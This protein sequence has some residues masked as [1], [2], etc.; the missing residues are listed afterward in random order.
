MAIIDFK[1]IP[2]ANS[3]GG[4]Q[5]TFELFARDFANEILGLKIISQPN[6]GADG[7]KDFLAEEIRNGT[8]SKSSIRWLVSCKHFAHSGKSVS[9]ND[10]LNISDRMH[11]HNADGFIGFY[12]TIA[13]SGLGSRL[14]ALKKD[15]S[16]EIFD[17]KKIE[18]WLLKFKDTTLFKRYFPKSFEKWGGKKY[19]PTI[20][21]GEYQPLHC[22]VCGKDLL[23]NKTYDLTVE[24]GGLIVFVEKFETREVHDVV[25]VCHGE[26]DRKYRTQLEKKGFIT[27]WEY[28]SDFILPTIYLKKQMALI[29]NLFYHNSQMV[30]T[31]SGI[32]AY[33]DILIA[34][35]QLVLRDYTEKE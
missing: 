8:L 27:S 31:E 5:D 14:E 7:G 3:G 2:C 4:D 23:S 26:C 29:N 28:I 16:V 33:K 12:S 35:S 10:E 24:A 30:F 25:G 9:D 34:L 18:Q 15:Y 17:G 6:R 19:E 13:S 1:E 20:L 21:L 11:Q 32:E 22:V